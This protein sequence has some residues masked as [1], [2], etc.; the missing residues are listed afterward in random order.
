MVPADLPD[1]ELP[2]T[3]NWGIKG[4]TSEAQKDEAQ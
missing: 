4:T 1:T 2:Q 3:F